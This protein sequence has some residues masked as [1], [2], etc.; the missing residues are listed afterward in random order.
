MQTLAGGVGDLKKVLDNVKTRG[1][2]GEVQLGNLL[3]QIFAPQQYYRNHVTRKG[4][5]S[6]RICD[7]FPGSRTNR[8]G[9]VVAY[10]CEDS[11]ARIMSVWL[12]RPNAGSAAA[13]EVAGKAMEI[14]LRNSAKDIHDKYIAPPDT[15]DFAI[16]FLPTEGLYAEAL[17]RPGSG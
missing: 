8:A 2:W 4:G 11:R 13:V 7:P 15:T 6:G 10:R 12:M 3:D 14:R 9:S 5:R 1:T 16:M 17:R